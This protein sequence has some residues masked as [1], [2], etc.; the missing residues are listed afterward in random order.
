MPDLNW[1]PAYACGEEAATI[2]LKSPLATIVLSVDQDSD[3]RWVAFVSIDH[4]PTRADTK[5]EAK[6]NAVKLLHDIA[7]AVLEA[8]A[9]TYCGDFFFG[10][11][12]CDKPACTSKMAWEEKNPALA[13]MKLD[14]SWQWPGDA[15]QWPA[16]LLFRTAEHAK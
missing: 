12:F 13:G 6:A 1:K 11:F 4:A 2:V 16:T 3:D 10:I 15:E 8:Q 5:E 7:K 9:R 14:G